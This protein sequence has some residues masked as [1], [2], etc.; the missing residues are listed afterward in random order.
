MIDYLNFHTAAAFLAALLVGAMTFFSFA[1][2]PVVFRAL[3]RDQAGRLL[4]ALFPVYYRSMAAC[5]P[6]AV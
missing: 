4:G 1:L 2:T 5:S 6:S 3:E